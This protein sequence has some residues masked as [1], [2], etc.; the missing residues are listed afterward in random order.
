M[1]RVA[2]AAAAASYVDSAVQDESPIISTGHASPSVATDDRHSGSTLAQAAASS[3]ADLVHEVSRN[4]FMCP[5]D[6]LHLD[7]KRYYSSKGS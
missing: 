7:R 6:D 2:A 5:A 1:V 3:T 4:V